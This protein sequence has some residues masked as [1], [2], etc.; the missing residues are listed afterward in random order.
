[1]SQRLL[2][3]FTSRYSTRYI[4]TH[5]E[6]ATVCVEVILVVLHIAAENILVNT[7]FATRL[8]S[9]MLFG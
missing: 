3:A 2:F 7:L 1:M 4:Y 8:S 9:E 5:T 6:C